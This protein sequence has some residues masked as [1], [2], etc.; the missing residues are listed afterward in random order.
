MDYVGNSGEGSTAWSEHSKWQHTT[1][2][3]KITLALMKFGNNSF[4]SAI[5]DALREDNTN[6][7]QKYVPVFASMM[8]VIVAVVTAYAIGKIIQIF[9][10]KEIVI[11]QEI[12]IE[13]EVKLSDLIAAKK[14]KDAISNANESKKEKKRRNAR[15]KTSK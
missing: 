3:G 9:V 12:I 14:D 11:N 2:W 13:E 15:S 4:I 7:A 5:V 10:G 8:V 1:M 6:N